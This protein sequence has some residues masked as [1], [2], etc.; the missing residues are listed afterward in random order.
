[1][2]YADHK[3]IIIHP[4]RASMHHPLAMLLLP[5]C[6]EDAVTLLSVACTPAQRA[7]SSDRR[8][9]NIC[10]AGWDR[11]SVRFSHK[12]GG[13]IVLSQTC[14]RHSCA[15]STREGLCW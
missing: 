9:Y 13:L 4:V 15:C 6:C 10:V 14:Q 8:A 12:N 7:L 1:M 5:T 11:L 3:Y 2:L